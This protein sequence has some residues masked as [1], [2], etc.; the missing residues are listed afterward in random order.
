MSNKFLLSLAKEELEA[1][2]SMSPSPPAFK[3]LF[4]ACFATQRAGLVFNRSGNRS[5]E[6]QSVGKIA[7]CSLDKWQLIMIIVATS[8]AHPK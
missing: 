8:Y 6:R 4:P 7:S 2:E 3:R 5:S 1:K